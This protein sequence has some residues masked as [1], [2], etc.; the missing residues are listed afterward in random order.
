MKKSLG[1]KLFAIL[2]SVMIA[3]TQTGCII[4]LSTALFVGSAIN[5][6]EEEAAAP[7]TSPS[8]CEYDE[9]EPESIPSWWGDVETKPAPRPQTPS[10]LVTEYYHYEGKESFLERTTL[11]TKADSESKALVL[12][13][14]LYAEA[15][16]LVSL[17]T[18]AEL[19]YSR[20]TSNEYYS[21]E[22]LYIYDVAV[23]CT[24]ALAA[25]CRELARGPYAEAFRA[26]VG[27]KAYEDFYDYLVSD[28]EELGLYKHEK[29]LENEYDAI[30]NEMDGLVYSYQ[31]GRLSYEELER[32]LFDKAAPIFAELVQIRNDIA[33]DQGYDNYVDYAYE[34]VYGRDYS[35][36]EAQEYCD[37]VKEIAA[38]AG[39]AV[40]RAYDKYGNV[41]VAYSTEKLLE[42]LGTVTGKAD[43]MLYEEWL[44]LTENGL[45][46]IGTEDCRMNASYTTRFENS[47]APFIFMKAG[48]DITD[49]SSIVHE[50]GHFVN[51][52]RKSADNILVSVDCMDLSEVHSTA[53]VL[54]LM[55]YFQPL[56][57][58]DTQGVMKYEVA[59]SLD[60][61]ISGCMYDEFQRRVYS[62]P[63]MTAEEIGEAFA[64]IAEEYGEARGFDG[65]NY[66]WIY[67]PH[68]FSSPLYYLSYSV[69]SIASLQLWDTACSDP[70]SALDIWKQFIEYSD[71]TGG[72]SE[73]TE[74]CGL[75]SIKDKD[76][77]IGLCKKAIEYVQ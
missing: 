47:G 12:Y 33:K 73:I 43:P 14:E 6:A 28:D 58:I 27:D 44:Y 15:A 38:K 59:A 76:A 63:D 4:T 18:A 67:V 24:E 50:F 2:F 34:N 31:T 7:E 48:G 62:E 1:F 8:W 20:D 26:H 75:F 65:N 32:A 25:A 37:A 56:F 5:A 66:E 30:W 69:S 19:A 71:N 23:D 64:E 42:D 68:N 61:I 9:T 74:K 57:G 21:G 77:V 11:L 51:F 40:N 3:L 13:D 72:Y 46:D 36:K 10:E 49:L 16:E 54:I 17:Y 53:L 35:A 29:E 60:C 41:S 45:Y 70:A 39:R 22:Q 55:H 52:H